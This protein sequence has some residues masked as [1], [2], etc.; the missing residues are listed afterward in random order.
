MEVKRG[1]KNTE[2]DL[3][4]KMGRKR[5]VNIH[6]HHL[7]RRHVHVYKQRVEEGGGQH[8]SC[9]HAFASVKRSLPDFRKHAAKNKISASSS[10]QTRSKGF[11]DSPYE[12]LVHQ[13][14]CGLAEQSCQL[15]ICANYLSFLNVN[16]LVGSAW[17]LTIKLICWIGFLSTIDTKVITVYRAITKD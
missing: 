16:K 9:V 12:V 2:H 10:G 7:T 3:K 11:D 14:L 6:K 5:E 17:H 15:S 13:R 1:I 4:T 8:V